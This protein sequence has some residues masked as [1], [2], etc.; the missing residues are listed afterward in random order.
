MKKDIQGYVQ[1]CETCQRN[2]Y[3]TLS[4]AG[5]LQ[6]LPIPATTWTDLTMDFLGGLP[7]AKGLDTIL[8]VVYK[9]TKY[10]H[11]LALSHP[12]TAKQVAELFIRE[13]VRLHGFPQTIVTDQDRLFMSHFWI[14]LFKGARTKL[15]FSTAYHPQTD[16]QTKVVNRCLSTYLLCF[17]GMRP[18]SWS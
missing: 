10:A 13:V 7:K 14:E 18:K 11:F 16:G 17:A 2:K 15:R 1:A 8:V 12:F 5:L 9:F 4:L 6:P 3:E